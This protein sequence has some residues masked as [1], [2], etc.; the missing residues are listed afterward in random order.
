R[1]RHGGKGPPRLAGGNRLSL[2]LGSTIPLRDL[3]CVDDATVSGCL[4]AM[5]NPWNLRPAGSFILL[6]TLAALLVSCA[7]KRSDTSEN[8]AADAS[9]GV[10]PLESDGA[11]HEVARS[12]KNALAPLPAIADRFAPNRDGFFSST[13]GVTSH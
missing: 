13:D 2:A 6:S 11:A 10:A 3:L 4:L 12:L 8:G 7:S 1:D 5:G 9:S